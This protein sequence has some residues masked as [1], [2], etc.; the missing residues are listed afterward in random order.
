MRRIACTLEAMADGLDRL[1]VYARLGSP[2]T[3]AE[4]Q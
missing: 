2:L 3:R 1:L 4:T